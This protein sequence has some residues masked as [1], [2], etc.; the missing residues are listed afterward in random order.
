MRISISNW[1]KTLDLRK[2]CIQYV[3]H[4]P[5]SYGEWLS[6]D[7]EKPRLVYKMSGF[8]R[9]GART[10]LLVLAG[11]DTDRTQQLITFF[12]PAVTLLGLQKQNQD[13]ANS[14]RMQRLRERFD[15]DDSTKLFELDAFAPDHG[16]LVIESQMKEFLESH[17]IIMSSLGPKLSAV[18]LYRIYRKHTEIGLAY[19]PSCEF[20]RSYSKG[21]GE[22]IE[23]I[24]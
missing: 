18:S 21:M 7:P 12:E 6:R 10:V 2:S 9:L 23:G 5:E 8:A 4:R 22:A 13:K 1:F 11:Y 17:N 14:E 24:V 20:N 15:R 3:Y 16:Q 19:A